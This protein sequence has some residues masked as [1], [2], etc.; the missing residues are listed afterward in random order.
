MTDLPSQG[1]YLRANRSGY[2]QPNRVV[3]KPRDPALIREEILQHINEEK[4]VRT[5][6]SQLD[7]DVKRAQAR[8]DELNNQVKT[9]LE[10][11]KNYR[12]KRDKANLQVK[13]CK[14]RRDE[15]HNRIGALYREAMGMK[16][17]RDNYLGMLREKGL[18]PQTKRTIDSLEWK[19][20]T[21]PMSLEKEREIVERIAKLSAGLEYEDEA[22]KWHDKMLKIFDEVDKLREEAQEWHQRVERYA[23]LSQEH[24]DMMCKMYREADKLREEADKAHEEFLSKLSELKNEKSKLRSLKNKIAKL[25]NEYNEAKAMRIVAKIR[26]KRKTFDEVLAA[27]EKLKN[28]EK[29]GLDEIYLLRRCKLI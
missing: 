13:E 4:L 23:R 8:R 9:V 12:E 3:T 28:G 10:K 1:G 2:A 7:E 11:A 29:L 19:I 24:H 15:I 18:D 21:V 16:K 26:A 20:Q 17:Q 5:R 14:E 22:R 25:R 27:M 6:I